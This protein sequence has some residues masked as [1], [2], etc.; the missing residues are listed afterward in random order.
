MDSTQAK[1]IVC[2]DADSPAR[3]MRALLLVALSAIAGCSGGNDNGAATV[4][5]ELAQA[6]AQAPPPPP[7]VSTD[8]LDIELRAL[9]AVLGLT[10]DPAAGRNLPNIDAP[11]PQLGKRLFFSK[12]LGGGLDTACVSCHHPRLGGGD[13]LSLSV[14]T[15]TVEPDLL[16]PGRRRADGIPN[17]P[18]NAPTTFNSGLRDS[19]MFWD[20]RIESINKDP[21]QNGGGSGIRTPD[22]PLL[23]ADLN[24][25]VGTFLPAA[26]AHFPPTS[27]AEMK[28]ESFEDG[29]DNEQIRAHLAARIGDY[30]VGA[31][32]LAT[33]LWLAE[34]QTAFASALPAAQLITFANIAL[35]IGEYERSMDFTDSAWRAY[36]EGDDAAITDAAK[37]GALLFFKDPDDNGFGCQQCHAGDFFSDGDHHT[38]GFPNIGPGRGDGNNDDFGR[39]HETSRLEDR[40]RF[41]TPSLLNIEVTGP[42]GHAGAYDTLD[43]VVRHYDNQNGTVDNFFDDGGWCQLEQFQAVPNCAD[44]Y[45]DAQANTDIALTKVRRERNTL[46][47]DEQVPQLGINGGERRDVIEFLETLTDACVLDTVCLAPWIADPASAGPDGMQLNAVDAVGDPL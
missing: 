23:S 13:G 37:R 16:G 5:P 15:G 20:S 39:A 14:G 27:A 9:V 24:L 17:V 41:R 6:Q 34:F 26:Q 29:S 30:G 46:P 11:I 32:E 21:G 1:P 2:R 44:L 8:P 4:T 38:I 40:Y 3:F 43:E 36:V 28:T 33:N 7:P 19:G 42:Y 10:G 47:P 25:S 18:R 22:S 31:G 35:A 45:P 12:S